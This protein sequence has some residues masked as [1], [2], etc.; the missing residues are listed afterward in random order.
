ML[1]TPSAVAWRVSVTEDIGSRLISETDSDVSA[2]PGGV[3]SATRL[4]PADRRQIA[5][6]TV[7]NRRTECKSRSK[8]GVYQLCSVIFL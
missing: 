4:G 2:G 1:D 6:D 8:Q 5:D 7:L 3:M